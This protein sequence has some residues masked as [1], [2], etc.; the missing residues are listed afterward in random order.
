MLERP[1]FAV[2]VPAVSLSG[3]LLLDGRRGIGVRDVDLTDTIEKLP[4]YR[5]QSALPARRLVLVLGVEADDLIVQLLGRLPVGDRAA[6]LDGAEVLQIEKGSESAG[7]QR[8][9][10]ASAAESC[11]V[12]AVE[13]PGQCFEVEGKRRSPRNL[14]RTFGAS[15]C[16]N[17]SRCR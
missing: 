13:H 15:V 9:P 3:A 8:V 17:A 12:V 4:G 14:V 16:G 7:H 2:G 5:E 1:K 6:E 10:Q 11:L